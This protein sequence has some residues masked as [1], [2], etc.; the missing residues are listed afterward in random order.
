MLCALALRCSAVCMSYAMM[1]VSVLMG[2]S[3]VIAPK[4]FA[5]VCSFRLKLV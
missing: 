5:I 1:W 2:S 3:R 4:G